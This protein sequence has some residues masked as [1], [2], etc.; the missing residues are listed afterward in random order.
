MQNSQD[1]EH[2]LSAVSLNVIGGEPLAGSGFE[3]EEP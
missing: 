2:D 1:F 3:T